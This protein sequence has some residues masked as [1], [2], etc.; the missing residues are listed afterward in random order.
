MQ[1]EII[2]IRDEIDR[3]DCWLKSVF[4]AKSLNKIGI[5]VSQITSFRSEQVII[6]AMK[7]PKNV[8]HLC[9]QGLGLT[10]DD[11]TKTSFVNFL[12]TIWYQPWCSGSYWK[13]PCAICECPNQRSQSSAS[14]VAFKAVILENR[15]YT[16]VGMDG[17]IKLFCCSARVP[18]EMKA[19]LT[20]N[21]FQA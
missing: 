16:A 8:F 13:I 20:R 14:N 6:S 11:I 5:E 3:S 17:K 19:L 9:L 7:L 4:L 2:T 15:R 21:L 1:A 10:K 18:Y 12:M